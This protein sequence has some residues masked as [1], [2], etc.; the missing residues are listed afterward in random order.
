M[1]TTERPRLSWDEYGMLLAYTASLRSPDPYVMVGAAAFRK[2]RSTLATGY[3]GAAPGIEIDWSDRDVRRF[4]V[5]HA[6]A[7]CLKYTRKGAPHYL[8]VTL[9]PCGDCLKKAAA[10]GVKEIIYGEIYDRDKSALRDAPLLD[11][12]IRQLSINS[13]PRI[14]A[15]VGESKL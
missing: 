12:A 13:V 3:N 15:M 9:L 1:N 11:I 2:N 5:H 8:Y 6:E 14:Q 10:K 4:F 7:N